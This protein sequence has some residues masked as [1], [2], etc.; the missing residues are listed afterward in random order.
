MYNMPSRIIA[1]ICLAIAIT[2]TSGATGPNGI[3]YNFVAKAQTL[4]PQATVQKPAVIVETSVVRQ[5]ASVA[6]SDSPVSVSTGGLGSVIGGTNCVAC[7]KAMTGRGQNGNA[8]SWRATSSTPAVGKIMIFRPGQQGA[9]SAGHVGLV[10]GVHG[11]KVSLRHCNWP[12]QTEFYS[13]GLF[14]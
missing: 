6:P 14:F 4:S 2:V 11:N 8:G 3:S 13:T 10:V 7:V 9:S 5:N 12:G 1:S